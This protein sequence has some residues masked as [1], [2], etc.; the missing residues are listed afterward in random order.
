MRELGRAHGILMDP[1]KRLEFEKRL[2]IDGLARRASG[3]AA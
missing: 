1:N 3:P 2:G